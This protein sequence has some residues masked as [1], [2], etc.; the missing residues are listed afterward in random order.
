MSDKKR[1]FH[2][3][4]EI[5]EHYGLEVKPLTGAEAGREL[6]RRLLAEFRKALR[7]GPIEEGG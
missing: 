1:E 7:V 4:R 6:A 2:T 5:V 3:V